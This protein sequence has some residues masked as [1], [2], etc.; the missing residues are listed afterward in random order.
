M[1]SA[2]DEILLERNRF[3]K[4]KKGEG[5]LRGM[6][7]KKMFGDETVGEN[8]GGRKV[9]SKRLVNASCGDE[10]EVV[11]EIE[12]GRIKEGY[13][14]GR[15]CAIAQASADLM[16]GELIG[17]KVDEAELL[18]GKFE[19]MIYKGGMA[20]ELG[21]LKALECV[22]RMPARGECAM[23]AWGIVDGLG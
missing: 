14:Q 20:V 5:G 1:R 23:L 13:W 16:V 8:E 12:K 7:G 21:E 6:V 4:Y 2:Y 9:V 15:G 10:L 18:K 17:R 11:L 19:K 3:P 22:A